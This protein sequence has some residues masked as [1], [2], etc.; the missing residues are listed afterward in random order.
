MGELA[1]WEKD[2]MTSKG[3]ERRERKKNKGMGYWPGKERRGGRGIRER[4]E[5]N[6][7]EGKEDK[8]EEEE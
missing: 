1:K 7:L 2:L 4:E 5:D 8:E 3:K 6:G